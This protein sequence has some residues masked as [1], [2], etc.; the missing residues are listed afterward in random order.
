MP[1]RSVA[2]L[3]PLLIAACSS[4]RDTL[5]ART[6]TEQLLISTAVDNAVERIHIDI[7]D[8][9][10]VWVDIGNFE[11]YDQKYAIA[12]IRDRL[13]RQGARLV[14]ERAEADAVVEIRTGAL[15]VD[16]DDMLV[17]IPSTDLPIPLA[18]DAKTPEIPFVKKD[19]VRGVAKIG[20]TAY[21]AKTGAL[22]PYSP[23]APVYGLSYRTRWDALFVGWTNSDLPETEKEEEE[24]DQS[25]QAR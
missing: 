8:E 11:G 23:S 21:D 25:S 10:K 16:Q 4:S 1:R 6:A 5:P 15:S 2:L 24:P 17:G 9:T 18:G 14:A 19:Q 3:L 7:P 13:L 20:L 12:A 22:L